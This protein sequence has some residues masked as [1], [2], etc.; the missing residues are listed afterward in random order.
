MYMNYSE[1][2][3]LLGA[4]P[5]NR[6][7]EFLRARDS[8]PEFREA[9][10]EADRFESRLERALAV[11]P[12]ADLV[13]VLGRIPLLEQHRSKKGGAWWPTALA[14]SLLLAVGAA[15]LY[16]KVQPAWDTVPDY[17]VDHYRHDGAMLLAHANG[18]AAVDVSDM[19]AAFGVK[20]EPELAGIVRVVKSCPTPDGKG[21][22]MVLNTERGLIT[23]IYMPETPVADGERLTFDDREA[24]LV[25][26]PKGS[27]VIIGSSQQSIANFQPLVR[28]AIHPVGDKT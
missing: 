12:P 8:S 13:E 6:D 18:D 1:Y 3:R 17:V 23:V 19:L 4:D 26:L 5:R 2:T 21:V 14:A 27:A 24:L 25:A 11:E 10:L 15:G 16:W 9:A 22:H 20:A 28:G 7:P